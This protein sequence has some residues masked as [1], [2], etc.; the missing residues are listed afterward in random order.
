MRL[1]APQGSLIVAMNELPLLEFV[2]EV[3]LRLSDRSLVPWKTFG[4]AKDA[5]FTPEQPSMSSSF[6]VQS[7]LGMCSRVAGLCIPS[8]FLSQS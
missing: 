5:Q 8:S 4:L 7:K 1:L 6:L 3:V 2:R